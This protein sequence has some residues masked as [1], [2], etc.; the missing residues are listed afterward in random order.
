MK[1][2]SIN[3]SKPNYGSKFVVRIATDK[4]YYE[5]S[6]ITDDYSLGIAENLDSNKSDNLSSCSDNMCNNRL[7][8]MLV[9]DEKDMRIYLRKLFEVDYMV[10]E[11]SNGREA[12]KILQHNLPDIIISDIKMPEMDGIE[13]CREIKSN[14][15]TSHIP[16]LLLTGHNS[17][18]NQFD[19][20]ESGANQY[21]TKPFN[22]NLLQIRV[23]KLIENSN[24]LKKELH[25]NFNRGVLIDLGTTKMDNL[26]VRAAEIINNNLSDPKFN[27]NSLAL[28]LN[29]SRTSFY[30]RFK[31]CIEITPNEFIQVIRLEKS[32]SLLDNQ[33]LTISEVAYLVG[34]NDAKYFSTS[35]KKHFNYSP[36]DYRKSIIESLV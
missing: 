28:E 35:F 17:E 20:F 25:F 6:E 31:E 8:V 14:V 7:C 34:F 32:K 29:L 21:V 4:D 22:P 19:C 27:I 10:I 12:T 13:L 5:K 30:K 26:L 1:R 24:K 15:F 23:K 18:K 36:R 16:F 33:E 2:S 11:A 9:D 3:W